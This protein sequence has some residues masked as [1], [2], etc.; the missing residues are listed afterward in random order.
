[1]ISTRLPSMT[2]SRLQAGVSG[3]LR[4]VFGRSTPAVLSGST[5][6]I[7]DTVHGY[8]DT[9]GVSYLIVH[10]KHAEALLKVIAELR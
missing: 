3:R 6:E 10:D 7:A 4:R 9:Y 8:R 2:M 1:V 5:R